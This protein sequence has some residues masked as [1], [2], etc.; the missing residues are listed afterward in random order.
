M[1]ETTIIAKQIATTAPSQLASL[2]T[3]Q[4]E[5]MRTLKKDVKLSPMRVFSRHRLYLL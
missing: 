4:A 1:A 5:E 2:S 3:T